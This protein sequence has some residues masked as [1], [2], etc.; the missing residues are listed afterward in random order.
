MGC[1]QFSRY[2]MSNDVWLRF[3]LKTCSGSL[4]FYHLANACFIGFS[5]YKS[6]WYG[7]KNKV[8]NIDVPIV[9]GIFVLYGR[10]IYEVVNRLW[11]D[12][13]IL[14]AVCC[15]LCCLGK[16]SKKEPTTHYPTTEIT[17]LSIRLPLPKLILMERNRGKYFAV[18]LNR[19]RQNC[20]NREIIPARSILIK[21]EGN[22]DNSFITEEINH[23]SKNTATKFLPAENNRDV[24]IWLL[25][26]M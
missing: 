8:V 17:N 19:G 13:S 25:K 11:R 6:A 2:M 16:R 9:L 22:I 10:S 3:L 5:Y 23:I 26:K 21:G 4:C 24:K 14:F 18:R 15:S 1:F 20:R 12:I 7:L